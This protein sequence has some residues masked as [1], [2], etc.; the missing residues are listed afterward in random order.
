MER[1]GI[2]IGCR[3]GS[4]LTARPYLGLWEMENSLGA[5]RLV[6]RISHDGRFTD[7]YHDMIY[8]IYIYI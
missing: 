3:I 4:S 8:I 2:T 1:N 6:Q 7:L 5:G